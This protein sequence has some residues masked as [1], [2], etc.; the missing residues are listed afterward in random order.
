MLCVVVG[1]NEP[2]AVADMEMAMNMK[3][4]IMVLEGSPLCNY[5]SQEL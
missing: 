1:D 2:Q 3:L 5:I 4:P